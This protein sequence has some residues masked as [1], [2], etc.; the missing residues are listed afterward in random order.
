MWQAKFRLSFS[1]RRRQ[2]SFPY[3]RK[4]QKILY[5]ATNHNMSAMNTDQHLTEKNSLVTQQQVFQKEMKYSC[6]QCDFETTRNSTMETF[7]WLKKFIFCNMLTNL[8]L[9]LV[10]K[11]KLGLWVYVN[12][13]SRLAKFEKGG[14]HIFWPLKVPQPIR[15][16]RG[17]KLNQS[18]T[19]TC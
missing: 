1:Y 15:G 3:R 13:M 10:L 2:Y 12:P 14:F 17:I 19:R 4:K 16:Q 7:A 5:P 18:Y 11:T 6:N 9:R 8:L